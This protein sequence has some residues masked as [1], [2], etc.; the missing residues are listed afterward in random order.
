MYV[1]GT[2]FYLVLMFL[3]FCSP[4]ICV[5]MAS[6]SILKFN[7]LYARVVASA[8]PVIVE[9]VTVIDN[10]RRVRT[11]QVCNL[12]DAPASGCMCMR[13]SPVVGVSECLSCILF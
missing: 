3:R 13:S 9:T 5:L 1:S 11:V 7:T 6:F 4:T 2:S 8:K 10:L 12:S